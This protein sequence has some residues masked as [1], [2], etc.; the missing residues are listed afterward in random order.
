LRKFKGATLLTGQ[1]A[2]DASGGKCKG[3]RSL[4][5]GSEAPADW[6][7]SV[8][9]TGRAMRAPTS[10][11]TP[12]LHHWSILGASSLAPTEHDELEDADESENSG[13][14]LLLDEVV[15]IKEPEGEA[16]FLWV[17]AQKAAL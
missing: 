17:L 4:A 3:R 5:H 14:S 10:R 1:R 12:Q 11:A 15:T 13:L 9:A 6:I 2:P 7:N 8:S 16:T